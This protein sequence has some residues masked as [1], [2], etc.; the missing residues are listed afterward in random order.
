MFKAEDLTVE[1]LKEVVSTLSDIQDPEK[2]KETISNVFTEFDSDENGYL[3]RS[4]LKNFLMAMVD[5]LKFKMF[6]DDNVVDYIF[7]KIDADGNHKIEKEE[8]EE[9]VQKFIDKILPHYQAALLEK[10]E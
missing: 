3:D 4:E 5:K 9:Y 8:L 1:E 10:G 6:I 2:F 7:G